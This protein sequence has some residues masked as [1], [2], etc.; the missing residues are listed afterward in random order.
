MRRRGVGRTLL[1]ALA[2]A[3]R[4]RGLTRLVLETSADWDDAVAFCSGCGF[5]MTHDEVGAFGRDA[6]FVRALGVGEAG[7]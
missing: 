7:C 5:T 4:A 1:D 6:W 2:A 3:A